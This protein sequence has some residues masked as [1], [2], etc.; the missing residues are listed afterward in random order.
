MHC[1]GGRKYLK[2]EKGFQGVGFH[3]RRAVTG[4]WT[5]L[6]ALRKGAACIDGILKSTYIFIRQD[7]FFPIR[8][9]SSRGRVILGEETGL[10]VARVAKG[11]AGTTVTAL[12]SSA[13][14]HLSSSLHGSHR[15]HQPQRAVRYPRSPHMRHTAISMALPKLYTDIWENGGGGGSVWGGSPTDGRELRDT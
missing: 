14:Y 15:G 4:I 8:W 5:F 1:F 3:P 10:T 11:V 2:K 9:I 13:I 12:I 7:Y 6:L